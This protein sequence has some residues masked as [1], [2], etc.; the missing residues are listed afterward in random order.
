VDN[1]R[2]G[3]EEETYLYIMVPVVRGGFDAPASLPVR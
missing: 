2:G 1:A 3:K